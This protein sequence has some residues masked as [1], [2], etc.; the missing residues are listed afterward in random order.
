MAKHK[1]S[2]GGRGYPSA[3]VPEAAASAALSGEIADD[4]Y[5]GPDQTKD[6]ESPSNTYL[7]IHNKVTGAPA[8]MKGLAKHKGMSY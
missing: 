6:H 5:N 7:G 3:S 4:M 1:M 8:K 2:D